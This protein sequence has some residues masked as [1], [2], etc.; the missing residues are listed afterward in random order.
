MTNS[1]CSFGSKNESLY[2]KWQCIMDFLSDDDAS[3]HKRT[4]KCDCHNWTKLNLNLPNY[5][6]PFSHTTFTIFEF[7]SCLCWNFKTI[8]IVQAS[9]Q[10]W[11]R[12]IIGFWND[13]DDLFVSIFPKNNVLRGFVYLI[14]ILITLQISY[15]RIEQKV[16]TINP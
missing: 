3:T 12:N 14:I 8:Y 5:S 7:I 15:K 1:E 10:M 13:S 9:N 2:N 11:K 4:G 16:V 6:E